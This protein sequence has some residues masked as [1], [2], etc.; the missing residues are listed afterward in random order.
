MSNMSTYEQSII[1]IMS[2]KQRPKKKK[3][4]ITIIKSENVQFI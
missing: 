1:I 3:E 2:S 4:Q